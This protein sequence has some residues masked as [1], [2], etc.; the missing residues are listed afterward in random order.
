M[1][2]LL[3]SAV[4][5]CNDK[6]VPAGWPMRGTGDGHTKGYALF[7]SRKAGGWACIMLAAVSHFLWDTS[8]I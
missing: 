5:G 6:R 4:S 2:E 1:K 8:P 7:S 3:F